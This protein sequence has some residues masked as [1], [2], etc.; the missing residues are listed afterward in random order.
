MPQYLYRIGA[1]F[2]FKS[3]R[4]CVWCIF[5]KISLEKAGQK[6]I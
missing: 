1:F 5:S 6:I 3:R 2:V 4:E